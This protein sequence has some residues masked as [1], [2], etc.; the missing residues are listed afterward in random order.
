MSQFTLF[1]N[2]NLKHTSLT[3]GLKLVHFNRRQKKDSVAKNI[4]FFVLVYQS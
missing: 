1:Y 4:F 2:V 3:F